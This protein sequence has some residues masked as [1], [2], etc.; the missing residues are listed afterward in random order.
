MKEGRVV[1]ARPLRSLITVVM[2]VLVVVA[3]LLT[4]RVV[5]RYFGALG[6][7]EW[8][9]IVTRL[10]GV[11]TLPFGVQD[12]HS[13]YSGVFDVSAVL[14]ILTLLVAEWILSI[15]RERL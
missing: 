10:G 5:A 2:N 12:L 4:V 1:G 13:S 9:S 11:F 8:G 3:V 7:S 6:A 14:T 15:V